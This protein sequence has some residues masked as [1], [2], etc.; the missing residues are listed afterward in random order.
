MK[1]KSSARELNQLTKS[2]QIIDLFFGQSFTH[3]PM[4]ISALNMKRKVKRTRIINQTR[5]TEADDTVANI[6]V[7]QKSPIEKGFSSYNDPDNSMMPRG[8]I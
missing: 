6:L 7:N 3:R 2:F 5:H 1:R 8:I 4:P